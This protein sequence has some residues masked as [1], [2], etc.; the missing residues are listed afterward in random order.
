MLFLSAIGGKHTAYLGSIFS[1]LMMDYN[2]IS[3]G[4][5]TMIFGVF[6]CLLGYMT[7]NWSYLGYI[8]SQLCCII[9]FI[10][11][12]SILFSFSSGVDAAAHF[13]GMIAGYCAT[14]AF[15]P[16]FG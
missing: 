4:S 8:R 13:G 5:S 2:T 10:L 7:L 11:F 9:G 14:L 3:V 16:S 1:L 15:F 6:G 12:F